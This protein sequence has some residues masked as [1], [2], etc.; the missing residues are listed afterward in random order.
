[1]GVVGIARGGVFQQHR[2]EVFPV[3][4][5]RLVQFLIDAGLDLLGQEA[6]GRHDDVVAGFA[7][8][9]ACLKGFVAVEDIVGHLDASLVLELLDGI[10]ANVIRPVIDA[11]N[12]VI[13]LGAG[14]DCAQ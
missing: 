8:Q 1:M 2:V 10:R 13:G 7:R 3:R 12:L 5:L 9:Q 4:Q 14:G 6:V 11:Q